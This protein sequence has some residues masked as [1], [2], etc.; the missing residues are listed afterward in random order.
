MTE[1]PIA[2]VTRILKRNGE[3]MKFT[4]EAKQLLAEALEKEGM[5]LGRQA[6]KLARDDGRKTVQEKDIMRW[7]PI[8]EM[9]DDDFIYKL[10]G[11]FG[12]HT[13]YNRFDSAKHWTNKD[14][15]VALPR[16]FLKGKLLFRGDLFDAD[17]VSD[18][19]RI[20]ERHEGAI[21]DS[22]MEPHWAYSPYEFRDWEPVEDIDGNIK[23]LTMWFDDY[24]GG[25]VFVHGY[26]FL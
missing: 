20:M 7:K 10:K 17:S 2:P 8:D 23:M 16:K 15:A 4:K 18:A 11:R 12:E 19:K 3:D 22:L 25:D 21:L 13:H 5:K 1:L 6:V 24:D 26:L 14:S 9:A